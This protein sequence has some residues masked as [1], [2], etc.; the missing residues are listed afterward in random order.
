MKKKTI[1]W[2]LFYLLLTVF[3]ALAL[4]K[5]GH[6]ANTAADIRSEIPRF[7]P[8]EIASIKIEWRTNCVT[9]DKKEGDWKLAE[10]GGKNASGTKVA[11][12]LESLSTLGVVKK[13]DDCGRG[14]LERLRLITDDPQIV[15]GITV[16][17]RDASGAQKFR[18]VLGKGHFVKPE[19]GM[20]PTEN[21]EGRYVRIGDGVYLIARVFEDCHP[22]PPAWVEPLRLFSLNKALRIT[23]TEN[24]KTL[25]S[26]VRANTAH[27]FTAEVPAGEKVDTAVLSQLADLLSKP[28]GLDLS[29]EDPAKLS[30]TSSVHFHCAD[31]FEYLLRSARKDK[32]EY[33]VV[34]VFFHPDKVAE[35]PGES[36]DQ[37]LKR[38]A[39]LQ[40][41]LDF[42]RRYF[43][44]NLFLVS[45]QV[46]L[47]DRIVKMPV[48]TGN[49]AAPPRKAE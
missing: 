46:K 40:N 44:D 2:L 19:P 33:A 15:P 6:T 32:R 21:A 16:T 20:P 31:G 1:F 8:D 18:I 29:M 23:A 38:K 25:W 9:L 22:I 30:F 37:L 27:P 11:R 39:Y 3:A 47:H 34:R 35:L 48:K 13:L 49:A 17:L 4:L 26:V 7:R 12:L 41:R 14:I 43:H 45:D 28:F 42:E 5:R 10:R 24:G 36:A